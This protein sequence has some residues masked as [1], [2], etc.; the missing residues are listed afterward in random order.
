MNGKL[1]IPTFKNTESKPTDFNDLHQLEGL[2][3]LKAQIETAQVIEQSIEEKLKFNIDSEIKKL[4][5]LSPI[6]YDKVRKEKAK[7]FKHES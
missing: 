6:E 5:T 1:I 3:I 7:L 4:A 2:E